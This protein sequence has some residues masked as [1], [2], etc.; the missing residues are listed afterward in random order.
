MRHLSDIRDNRRLDLDFR[1]W[2]PFA[3]GWKERLEL[4][5]VVEVA[6][7][8]DVGD[9]LGEPAEEQHSVPLL[10]AAERPIVL[11]RQQSG[12]SQKEGN[13]W[14]VAAEFLEVLFDSAPAVASGGQ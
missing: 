7:E 4:A 1:G 9:V 8:I 2:T 14:L 10:V 12:V 6:D 13:R 5:L 3:S 11:L